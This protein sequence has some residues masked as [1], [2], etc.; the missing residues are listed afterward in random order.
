MSHHTFQIMPHKP[1]YQYGNNNRNRVRFT[2]KNGLK[3]ASK[4]NRAKMT[5]KE[6]NTT[7]LP[8]FL[9]S[10]NIICYYVTLSYFDNKHVS[11]N[12]K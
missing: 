6:E 12:P 4:L 8:S 1:I 5:V 2:N 10:S 9:L 11:K 3:H 7:Y